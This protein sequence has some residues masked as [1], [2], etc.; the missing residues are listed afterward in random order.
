MMMLIVSWS[1]VI[2]RCAD[3]GGFDAII[4]RL[5][6]AVGPFP[7]L[8]R[9]AHG[10]AICRDWD[11]GWLIPRWIATEDSCQ[12]YLTGEYRNLRFSSA[13]H[14]NP[15]LRCKDG[16]RSHPISLQDAFPL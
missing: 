8:V 1:S 13:L 5:V 10:N 14:Q 9:I 15:H 12:R 3:T 6:R 7:K 2:D 11:G 4:R 16:S